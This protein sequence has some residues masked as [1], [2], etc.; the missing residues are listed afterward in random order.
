[1]PKHKEKYIVDET[2]KR[3]AIMIDMAT[4]RALLERIEDLEDTL[5]LDEAVRSAKSFRSLEDIRAE[6]KKAK[7]L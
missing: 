3:T 7:K 5:E 1:M 4:Y 2:G 6:L